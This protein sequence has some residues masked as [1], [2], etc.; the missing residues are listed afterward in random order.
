MSRK[1]K[2]SERGK[3]ALLFI[4]NEV[5]R[6]ML[7]HQFLGMLVHVRANEGGQVQGRGA[8]QLRNQPWIG[9]YGR[10][11]GRRNGRIE[12]RGEDF[13]RRTWYGVQKRRRRV[14]TSSSSLIYGEQA[15]KKREDGRKGRE[16]ETTS[17]S[18]IAVRSSRP[19]FTSTQMSE[20]EELTSW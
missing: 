17:A 13:S 6:H 12:K 7:G 3:H 4:V 20:A 8:V 10:R 2:E 16:G 5:C 1:K 18:E 19:S 14:R 11:D 9:K 15:S